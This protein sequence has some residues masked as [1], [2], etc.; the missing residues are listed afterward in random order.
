MDTHPV[1][2]FLFL[3]IY[4]SMPYCTERYEVSFLA[5]LGEPQ[6]HKYSFI[7]AGATVGF[8]RREM[9]FFTWCSILLLLQQCLLPARIITKRRTLKY[10]SITITVS[11][12][13]KICISITLFHF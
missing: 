6:N 8:L 11:N 9:C 7:M 3:F 12:F 13:M 5:V 2:I 1:M 4:R 10:R